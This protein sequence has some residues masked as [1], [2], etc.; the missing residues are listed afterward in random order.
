[1]SKDSTITWGSSMVFIT[2]WRQWQ[3]CTEGDDGRTRTTSVGVILERGFRFM[4]QNHH[5]V[6]SGKLLGEACFGSIKR[7]ENLGRQQIEDSMKTEKT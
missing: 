4:A 1:M 6:W 5:L 3:R 2:N 7:T